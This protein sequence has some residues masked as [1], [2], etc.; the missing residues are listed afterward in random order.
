MSTIS[1]S[2][3]KRYTCMLMFIEGSLIL[4][5]VNT[6]Y[7]EKTN[8]EHIYMNIGQ[9]FAS[10]VVFIMY[11]RAKLFKYIHSSSIISIC[12]LN[13]WYTKLQ[14]KQNIYTYE[15]NNMK[16]HPF[17]LTENSAYLASFES[18]AFKPKVSYV[19]G[20]QIAGFLPDTKA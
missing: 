17:Q 20:F 18:I 14:S 13:L 12:I 15:H 19:T 16:W 2:F 9:V 7:V 4:A 3:L 8:Y 11:Y 1:Y 10:A 6:S 5:F